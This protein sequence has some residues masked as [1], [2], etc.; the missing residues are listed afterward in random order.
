M[1]RADYYEAKKVFDQFKKE[2]KKEIGDAPKFVM[3]FAQFGNRTF[4]AFMGEVTPYEYIIAKWN[5]P[6]ARKDFGETAAKI[7]AIYE[8][9]LAEHGTP[10]KEIAAKIERVVNSNALKKF[11]ELWGI[12]WTTEVKT[13]YGRTYKYIRFRF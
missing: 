13:E 2:L 6:S 3:S 5:T 7:V 11:A 9:R 8:Q 10:E 4:T 12:R 1:T